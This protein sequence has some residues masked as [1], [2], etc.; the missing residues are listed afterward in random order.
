M[1]DEVFYDQN[2]VNSI[3]EIQEQMD[4]V[5]ISIDKDTICFV[6]LE[7][8]FVH[9]IQIEE[10]DC[11]LFTLKGCL[12]NA[13]ILCIHVDKHRV[14]RSIVFEIELNEENEPSPKYNV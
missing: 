13:N 14:I 11:K 3:A 4:D 2:R 7:N 1:K 10:P 6:A 12:L 5:Y 9:E 8:G